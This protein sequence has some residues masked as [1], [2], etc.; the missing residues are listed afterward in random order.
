MRLFP[1][2]VSGAILAAAPLVMHS[3]SA[4]DA[5]APTAASVVDDTVAALKEISAVSYHA[6][7]SAGGAIDGEAPTIE[8]DVVLEGRP[9]GAIPLVFR[10]EGTIT[11]PDSSSSEKFLSSFDGEVAYGV[12]YTDSVLYTGE[13][14]AGGLDLLTGTLELIIDAFVVADPMLEE[15]N[16]FETTLLENAE[17]DGV[18]CR[19]VQFQ[20]AESPEGGMSR[21]FIG[22]EDHLPR[23]IQRLLMIPAGEA[24]ITYELSEIN[25]TPEL[26]DG[27]FALAAPEGFDT[28]MYDTSGLLPIGSE[29]PDFTLTNDAGEEVT[30]S[31]MRG[32]VVVL[33]FWATWCGP[34]KAAMPGVQ[35]LHE[36]FAGQPVKIL[37]VNCWE[38]GPSEAA[39]EYFRTEKNYTYGL[40]LGGDAVAEAYKV[41][42][43]P[44]FYVIAPD[45]TI[46]YRSVGAAGEDALRKIIT[47][48]V[49]A[50]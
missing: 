35:E 26:A 34:C 47:E 9:E 23:R 30:L 7:L 25:T 1:I 42:G 12:N 10:G 46:A 14:G 21:W 2:F 17:V 19:V 50:S 48:T 18:E 3:A 22:A 6:R 20:Y 16:A 39:V 15:R 43:I 37:G 29:A 11:A 32:Q 8:G 41:T 28:E 13:L 45:G 33:D 31:E 27:A 24:T 44:T 4:Q 36:E 5:P 40:L 38:Q 49:P